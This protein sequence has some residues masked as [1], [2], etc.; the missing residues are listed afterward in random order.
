VRRAF[1][2]AQARRGN[3]VTSV[4]KANVLDTSRLWREVTTRIGARG[5]S[6]CAASNT[7]WWIRWRCT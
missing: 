6:R 2:L 4:D 7:N 1:R 3:L 5:V